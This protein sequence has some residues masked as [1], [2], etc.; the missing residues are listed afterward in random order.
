[1]HQLQ[2]PKLQMEPLLLPVAQL[3]KR[4]QHD[5][6]EA[7]QLLL[8]EQRG[9]P[10]RAALLVRRNPQ[11]FVPNYQQASASTFRKATE[12]VYYGAGKSSAIILPVQK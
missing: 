6:Q 7:R 3:V 4:A 5:I 10:S 1:M 2:Q 9:S 11:Q 8:A 12:R